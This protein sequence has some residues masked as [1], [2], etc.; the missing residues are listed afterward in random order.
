MKFTTATVVL[1]MPDTHDKQTCNETRE[2]YNISTAR[3]TAARYSRPRVHERIVAGVAGHG[4]AHVHRARP[5]HR[6]TQ[7]RLGALGT[8]VGRL[9]PAPALVVQIKLGS[10]RAGAYVIGIRRAVKANSAGVC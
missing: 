2:S 5:V 4:V 1:W 6:R 9:A 10:R 8:L 7:R 3:A